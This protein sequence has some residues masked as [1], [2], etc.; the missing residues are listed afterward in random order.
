MSRTR[1]IATFFPRLFSRL[2]DVDLFSTAASLSYTTLLGLVPLVAMAVAFVARFPLFS[3]WLDV[4]EAFLVKHL[5]PATAASVVRVHIIGFAE[6]AAQLS[7]IS[8]VFVVVTAMMLIATIEHEI[9]VIWGVTA[10]RPLIRRIAVYLFGLTLGPVLVGAS[11][12]IT[13][14]VVS[15]S[16]ALMP[17][18]RAGATLVGQ[19]LPFGFTAVALTLLYAIAPARH[20]P[21]HTALIGGVLA[22]V[23][24][25]A[26]KQGFAWYITGSQSYEFIYGALAAL[27]VFMLW[28][29]LSWLIVLAGAAITATLAGSAKVSVARS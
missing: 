15:R 28:I 14:F 25:E 4:L 9:N 18:D 10:Q 2:R 17:L 29:Y 27:P 20:V 1:S 5:L 22:A 11:I 23:A 12:S 13:T 7:G 3:T 26:A 21:K 8:I 16:L 24:F 19:W 6:R